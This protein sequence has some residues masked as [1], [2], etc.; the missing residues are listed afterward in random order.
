MHASLNLNPTCTLI[1]AFNHARI[2]LH[3]L[4]CAS[5]CRTPGQPTPSQLQLNPSPEPTLNPHANH[6]PVV[7]AVGLV[8]LLV[9]GHQVRQSEAVVGGDKVDG[10][11]G[12][13]PP[14]PPTPRI[15]APPAM[16]MGVGLGGGVAGSGQLQD[17]GAAGEVK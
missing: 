1:H 15:L 17:R 16:R 13:A 6:A 12:A 3:G 2:V 7:L 10:G 14:L 9:V 4:R 5:R 8:V 11:C